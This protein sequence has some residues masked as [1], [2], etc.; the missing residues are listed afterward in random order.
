MPGTCIPQSQVIKSY[1]K[2]V[3]VR[4]PYLQSRA[5]IL[6]HLVGAGHRAERHVCCLAEKLYTLKML[7]LHFMDEKPEA[8]EHTADQLWDWGSRPC[9]DPKA[10]LLP[11]NPQTG[12]SS[13]SQPFQLIRVGS[14]RLHPTNKK[15]SQKALPQGT[16]IYKVP[17][18]LKACSRKMQRGDFSPFPL[19]HGRG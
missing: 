4:K 1:S 15:P 12:G 19:G 18:T 17:R 3:E 13:H 6:Q 5:P 2:S 7:S 11:L 10:K 8:R 16:L 14:F 9:L